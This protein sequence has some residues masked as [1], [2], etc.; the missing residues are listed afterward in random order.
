MIVDD[1]AYSNPIMAQPLRILLVED[2]PRDAELIV[3]ALRR[4]GFEPDWRRVD[5]KADYLG[6]LHPGLDVIMS[7]F[8]LPDFGGIE[9]LELLKQTGLEIPCRVRSAKK[10][11]WKR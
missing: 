10:W 9:A 8:S 5:T 1:A 4:D 3:L 6:G 2:D 7:D 11:R